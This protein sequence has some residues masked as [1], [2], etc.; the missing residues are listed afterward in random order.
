MAGMEEAYIFRTPVT[1]V[2]VMVMVKIKV[3]ATVS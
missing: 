3:K 2:M 1:M